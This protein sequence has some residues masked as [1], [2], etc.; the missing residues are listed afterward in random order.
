MNQTINFT[1]ILTSDGEPASGF[2]TEL[3]NSLLPKDSKGHVIIPAAHLKGLIRE[4]LENLPEKAVPRLVVDTLFGEEGGT[5]ALFH[6][7]DAAAPLDA[8]VISVS[9]TRLNEAGTADDGSLRTSEAIAAGTRFKGSLSWNQDLPEE[10]VDLLK[11]GLLSLFA[12]GGGRNR[13]AGSCFVEVDGET[14]TP[15]EILKYLDRAR[16]QKIPEDDPRQGDQGQFCE[17]PILLKLVF[18]A[19][20]P[21]CVP[22]TPV[23]RNNVIRSGFVIPA[24][25][26]QGAILHRIN[27]ISKTA[28]DKCFENPKFRAWP[29]HPADGPQT[30]SIRC[31][32]THKISKLRLEETGEY[33]FEDSMI[34]PFDP[35]LIPA[36]SPLKS[37]DGVLLAGEDGVRLWKA[38]DMARI[39]SAHGVHNGDRSG[40]E[41]SQKRNLFTVEALAPATFTGLASMPETAAKIL[42]DSLDADPFVQIGKSR[43]VRGGGILTAEPLPDQSIPVLSSQ[44]HQVFIVQSPVLVPEELAGMNTGSILAQLVR[45][46]EF[47]EVEGACGATETRFG[48]NNTIHNGFVRG[49]AVIS[50]GAVFK[51]A[52]SV[53]DLTG[54]LA[55]G[56]G[57]GREQGFGA[58]LP[59]PGIAAKRYPPPLKPRIIPK[60]ERNFGKDGFELWQKTRDCQLSASQISRVRELVGLDPGSA[61]DYLNRQIQDRPAKIWE[62][63]KDVANH[64]ISEIKTNP[65]HI[66]K[67]LKVCQDL[68]V[69]DKEAS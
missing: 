54:K 39:I 58:V 53:A 44:G 69:A 65:D 13:G 43:S 14:R 68:R 37:A 49:R 12:V 15:G 52:A 9:R 2:G 35:G 5:G 48:W 33:H 40:T 29:L 38:S 45:D 22:E 31:S 19:S 32:F 8:E 61:V 46:A 55:D 66:Q 62:R 63:W 36:R 57:R 20:G 41:G 50:P 6:I 67:V 47:G 24:S 17:T 25:A 23:V 16:F 11:L 4:N 26:V 7:L 28:A 3:V 21:V 34:R 27:R 18:K 10:H 59:H 30:L 56:I 51:V 1:I 64:L 60:P 42:M